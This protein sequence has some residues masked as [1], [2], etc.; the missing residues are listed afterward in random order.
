VTVKVR[1]ASRLVL[2]VATLLL[3][4]VTGP[5]QAAQANN[6]SGDGIQP[7]VIPHFGGNDC[8]DPKVGNSTAPHS[9]RIVSPADGTYTDSVTGV[10]FTLDVLPGGR[11]FNWSIA[12]AGYGAHHVIA[13]GGTDSNHFRYVDTS[14]GVQTADTVLHAP[15]KGNRFDNLSHITFCY[16]PGLPPSAVADSY[17]TN[18]DT[19]LVVAAPGVLANDSDP[20]GDPLTATN[21]TDPANGTLALNADGSFTYTPDANFVGT[22]TFT[23]TATDGTAASSAATVSVTVFHTMCTGETVSDREGDVSGSF[24]RLSDSEDCKRYAVEADD[25]AGTV[26][27]QPE[28]L[29]DVVYRGFLEFGGED[30]PSGS[31][32]FGLFLEYDPTGG[33]IFQPVLWCIDPEFDGDGNVTGATIP[34]TETWCIASALTRG[35]GSALVTTWQVYGED[36][37]KFR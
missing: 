16:K 14:V 7:S 19:P 36:D 20:D 35:V 4:I 26:L 28:G 18:E 25:S 13:K 8:V 22:D 1:A 15:P 31:D 6:P 23:Y 30:P 32:P 21:A 3:L 27:F 33:D 5:V 24:T 10:T 37:P 29:V 12:T 9:F 34:G 11:T 2:L 17:E